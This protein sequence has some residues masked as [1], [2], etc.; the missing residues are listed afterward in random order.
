MRVQRWLRENGWQQMQRDG[1]ELNSEL[2]VAYR[3]QPVRD[4][5]VPPR[6]VFPSLP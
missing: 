4:K 3:T 1:Q 5:A 2:P 6:Q